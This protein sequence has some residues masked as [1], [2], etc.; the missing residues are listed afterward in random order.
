MRC[1]ARLLVVDDEE[2]IRLA[3]REYF[4]ARGYAVD[5]AQEIEEAEAL[6]NVNTYDIVIADLRL[7]GIHGAE[8]LELVSYVRERSAANV[9]LLT[10]YGT[11]EI[12]RVA[13]ERGATAF[14]HKPM[15]L[16]AIAELVARLSSGGTE[17]KTAC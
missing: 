14:L 15:P 13:Y 5:S 3:L 4:T 7:T 11:S 1:I 16:G 9:I 17:R 2:P 12:E 8:G 6:L 10:A